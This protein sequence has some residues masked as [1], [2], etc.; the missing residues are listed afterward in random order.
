M[1]VLEY[2]TVAAVEL[3]SLAIP[4]LLKR[5]VDIKLVR[6]LWLLSPQYRD[7]RVTI[8]TLTAKEA[9]HCSAQGLANP[10]AGLTVFLYRGNMIN[11]IN[12]LFSFSRQSIKFLSFLV[13]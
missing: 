4:R 5:G 2:M 10:V 6:A 11:S 3:L 1:V 8:L 7:S 13:L 12:I 9:R